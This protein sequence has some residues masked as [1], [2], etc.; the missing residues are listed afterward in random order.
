MG[1][2]VERK[3]TEVPSPPQAVPQQTL[4]LTKYVAELIGTMVL[5]FVGCGSAVL[6]A[7]F[8]GIQ[9]DLHRYTYS[10]RTSA[11]NHG[12]RHRRHFRMPHKPRRLNLDARRRKNKHQRHRF[13]RDFPM[14]RCNNRRR[15]A[16]RNIHWKPK[17]QLKN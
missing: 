8:L 1:E 11:V 3:M 16:L 15:I 4:P 5:V 9:Y 14:H 6:T 10:F 12:L 13:L 2:E 7:K 17:L